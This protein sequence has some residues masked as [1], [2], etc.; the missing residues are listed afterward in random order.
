MTISRISAKTVVC[1]CGQQFLSTGQ[2]M[3]AWEEFCGTDCAEFRAARNAESAAREAE[4][5]YKAVMA[6]KAARSAASAKFGQNA[7]ARGRKD[8][9]NRQRFG[10]RGR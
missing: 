6:K 5:A 7:A 1:S 2:Q 4:V 10:R 3:A 8:P 9:A